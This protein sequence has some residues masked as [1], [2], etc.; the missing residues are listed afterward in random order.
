MDME[1]NY[2]ITPVHQSL[3]RHPHVLGA[4]R[5]LILSSA[6][7]CFLVGMGGLTIISFISAGVAWVFSA[8]LLRKMATVDP[9]LSKVWLRHI[10]QQEYYP[11]HSRIWRRM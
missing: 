4:E 1:F 3:H 6:L 10:K 9:L 11:A 8:F 2:V 5:E 7:I